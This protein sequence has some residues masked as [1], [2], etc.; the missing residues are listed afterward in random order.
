[1]KTIL[2]IV[3]LLAAGQSWGQKEVLHQKQIWY[4]YLLKVPIGDQW[5]IRQEIDDRNFVDPAR[6]SQF[7]SRTFIQRKLGHEWSVA[8]GFA[9]FN[10]SLPQEPEIQDFYNVPELRPSFEISNHAPLGKKF[11]IHHRYWTEARFFKQP[12]EAYELTTFRIRYKLELGYELSD[13]FS[14][15]I[16]DEIHFNVGH[17][18][19][20]NVF[21]QNR[22]GIAAM[23]L[24]V[25]NI[26]FE[27][28]YINWFQ[29]A[30]QGDLFY[31]RDIVRFA[32][33]HTLDVFKG[34]RSEGLGK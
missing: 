33:H 19:T 15:L 23:Y 3:C 17:Q 22:Y 27:I 32:L 30:V 13:K 11:E 34:V 24:P 1:M 14:F 7:L 6:Q 21:D 31:D 2:V 9:Y 12:G 25:K 5:Q 20:Y 18:I 16:F 26:G 4:K 29:Q 28:M 10:H 8:L